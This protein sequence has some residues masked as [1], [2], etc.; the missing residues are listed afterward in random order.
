MHKFST[1]KNEYN[2]KISYEEKKNENEI[3]WI[4]K[5]D[6]NEREKKSE[7]ENERMKINWK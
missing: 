1:S 6:G 7:E 3:E 4:S 2:K 5:W